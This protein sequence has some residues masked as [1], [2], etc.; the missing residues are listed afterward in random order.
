MIPTFP[1]FKLIELSDKSDVEK[2]TSKFPPYSDFNFISMWSWNLIDEIALSQLN[3]NLV[4]RF[5]DYVTNNP[6]YSF[7]GDQK[8][9][10]TTKRLLDF[11][12]KS[13][14]PPILRLIPEISLKDIDRNKFSVEEDR[15]HFDYIYNVEELS[16]NP[17]SKFMK[18]RN[19]VNNF[20]NTFPNAT[21]KIISLR[22]KDIVDSVLKLFHKWHSIKIQKEEDSRLHDIAAMK[23]LLEGV[24]AFNLVTVG[25]FVGGELVA[26][27]INELIDSEYVLAHM[28]K[29]DTS[30]AASVY[31][32]LMKKN[33]EV[34]S[35][36]N[37]KFFNYEQDL[38]LDNLRIAKSRFNPAFFLKKYTLSYT[39]HQSL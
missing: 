11:S 37:R 33:A 36:F 27:F 16:Q 28:M 18:K 6:F 5:T 12:I 1:D 7:L 35:S 17:G 4:V 8:V 25:V 26:L 32:F 19:H 38:G 29:A 9:D 10:D 39:Q 14:L 13:G 34:L 22:D 23:R 2:F 15:N 20:L 24:E 3:G 21:E 30:V 31:A